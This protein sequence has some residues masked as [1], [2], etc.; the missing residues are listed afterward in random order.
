MLPSLV[1]AW[2][3]MDELLHIATQSGVGT[4]T[5]H[6]TVGGPIPKYSQHRYIYLNKLTQES[7]VNDHGCQ[8]IVPGIITIIQIILKMDTFIMGA[9]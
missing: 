5:T 8:F 3:L 9:I 2:R 1:Q 4:T 6:H 7:I